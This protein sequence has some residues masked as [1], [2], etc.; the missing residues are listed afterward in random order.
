MKGKEV[1]NKSVETETFKNDKIDLSIL[2]KKSSAKTAKGIVLGFMKKLKNSD[3]PLDYL[4]L[5]QEVYRK[6]YDLEESEK[7]RIESWRGKGGI[8][9]WAKPDRIIVEFAGKRDKNEKPKIQRKEYT[10]QEI[11]QMIVC[12]NKLKSEFDNKI[13]SRQLGEEYFG[14]NWDYKVFCKRSDHHKFTH[15]LNILDFYKIIR[16]NRSGYTTVLR[17]V[18]EIQEVLNS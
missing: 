6:I 7:I 10:K 9:V 5:L 1:F 15:L 13:P 14:G 2:R 8:K 18:K 11:N 17:E 4:I 12:I 16:Y 3:A